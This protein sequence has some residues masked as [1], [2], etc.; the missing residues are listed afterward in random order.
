ME[1]SV[2]AEEGE[3]KVLPTS[4]RKRGGWITFPFI[5]ATMGG[6]SLACGGWTMNL[7]VYLIEEFN[8]KSIDAAQIFNIVNGCTALFPILG[9]IIADSF[10]GCFSVIWISSLFSL[11]GVVIITVT[12]THDSLRPPHCETGS[13]FCKSP[14]PFQLSLLYSGLALGCLGVGGTRYTLG[15]MGANQFDNPKNQGSFFNWYFFTMYVSTMA[16]VTALVYIEDSVSWVLGFGLSVLANLLGLLI[17]VLGNRFYRHVEANGSPFTGL[18]R[19]IVAA[20]RKRSVFL[21]IKAEDYYQDQLG[22]VEKVVAHLPTKSLEF[23]NT[24]AVKTEGDIKL[25]GSIAK[26]WKLCTVKQVEDLKALIKIIPLWST[27]IFVATPIAIQ[28][29]LVVLQAL[30]MD[31][32]IGPDFQ[33]P[34]GSMVV[35]IFIFTAVSLTL[36]DRFLYPTWK[37]LTGRPP[38]PLQRIAVGHVLNVLS[39]AVSAMVESKRLNTAKSHQKDSILPISVIWLLPPLAIVGIGEAFHFPGQVSL[40]YQEFPAS[41]KSTATAMVSLF[42]GIAYYLSTAIVDSARRMTSW[43]PDDIN[44]GRLDNVYW[45]IVVLGVLNFTYFL[46]CSYFYEYQNPNIEVED[47]SK[48]DK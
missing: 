14:S 39:M 43:L 1:A 18:A 2:A 40:Y 45:V 7:M 27:G 4:T 5:I 36:I 26:P 12:S 15:T 20:V 9:A 38:T 11:L 8:V 32:H 24:A 48:L 46:V 37:K 28:G 33:I 10:L 21:S 22:G 3:A 42:I 31:R 13:S 47:R 23:L 6:L 35:F 34:A 44:H 16:S 41:L 17:F 25:D 29:S 19:V 30:T